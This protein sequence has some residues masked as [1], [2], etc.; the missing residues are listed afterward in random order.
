[1]RSSSRAGHERIRVSPSSA[2]LGVHAEHLQVKLSGRIAGFAHLPLPNLPGPLSSASGFFFDAPP[3]P[4]SA[5][6]E[7]VGAVVSAAK[8]S[9]S[10][11]LP[12]RAP[13][14]VAAAL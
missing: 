11:A 5:R 6:M 7:A 2:A 13:S 1:M 14:S 4:L 3:S 10:V 8:V 9:G 12:P